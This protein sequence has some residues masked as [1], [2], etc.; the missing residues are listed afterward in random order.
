[1]AG[2]GIEIDLFKV[3]EAFEVVTD[4]VLTLSFQGCA[5]TVLHG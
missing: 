3:V 5:L 2:G 4:G 1:M